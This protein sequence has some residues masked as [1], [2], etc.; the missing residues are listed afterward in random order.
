MML[1]NSSHS[2]SWQFE[3]SLSSFLHLY[4]YYLSIKKS[5]LR[6]IEAFGNYYTLF[7]SVKQLIIGHEKDP[8]KKISS[9]RYVSDNWVQQKILDEMRV[10]KF[11][12]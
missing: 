8:E 7:L 12:N 10:K 11:E 5:Y 4:F 2:S 1:R 3:N 6:K 9:W